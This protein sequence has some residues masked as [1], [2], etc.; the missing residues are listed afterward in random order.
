MQL[1]FVRHTAVQPVNVTGKPIEVSHQIRLVYFAAIKR[2]PYARER[3]FRY[4]E[5]S[6]PCSKSGVI[7]EG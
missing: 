5:V 2:G 1:A 4:K 6:Q 3:F 7:V